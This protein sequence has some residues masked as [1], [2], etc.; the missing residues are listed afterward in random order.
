MVL[1]KKRMVK[2]PVRCWVM[3]T[4]QQLFFADHSKATGLCIAEPKKER[5]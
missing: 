4:K 2:L 3:R 1:A 5:P